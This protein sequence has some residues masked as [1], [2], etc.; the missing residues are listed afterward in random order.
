MALIEGSVAVCVFHLIQLIKFGSEILY[1]SLKV[2][3]VVVV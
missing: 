1:Q 2:N 3:Y